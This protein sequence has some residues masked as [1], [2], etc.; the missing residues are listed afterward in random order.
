[1]A[2][3]ILGHRLRA[4]GARHGVVARVL[5]RLDHA[6][7]SLLIWL[8]RRLP[9]DRASRFGARI[10][11]ALGPRFKKS[12]ALDEN[13]RIALPEL[14]P[15]R[16]LEIARA[17]WANA[18]AVFAEYAHLETI[19]QP[20][21]GRLE[22]RV[23]QELSTLRDRSRPAIFVTAHQANWELAGAA[24]VNL[25]VPLTVV[26][27]PP[28]NPMLDELLNHWRAKL[29][30]EMLARDE[31]MRPMIRA[32]GAGRSLGIVMDRRVDSGKPVALFGRAKPTSLIPARLALRF[33]YELVPL[34]VERLQDAR[35][36]ASFY[37][38][39]VPPPAEEDEV[40]RAIRMTAEVH[41]LFEDWIRERP[42][43]WFPSKR[44]W[45]KDVY[46]DGEQN[47]TPARAA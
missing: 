15:A 38:A 11:A 46:R 29:G 22:V 23:L 12:Q 35:F 44:L 34:R 18:G 24:I 47:F 39:I 25:G 42:G 10:G 41:A 1:M 21:G 13:L 37:P 45:P 5:Y 33:G 8:I 6:F 40:A 19:A 7:F 36:R 30:C 2:R 16:R 26:Y 20:G 4:L 27:S 9:V 32:L 14:P 43:E 28:T 31:S 3:F 17:A